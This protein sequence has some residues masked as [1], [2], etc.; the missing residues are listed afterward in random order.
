MSWS[1]TSEIT[2]AYDQALAFVDYLA[3]QYGA[4]VLFDLV[5]ECKTEGIGGAEAAFE[6]QILVDL[7]V[8]LQDF[9]A[10]LR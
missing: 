2:R 8:V 9:A 5:A 7:N 6:R 3:E 1:D 4:R 10:A